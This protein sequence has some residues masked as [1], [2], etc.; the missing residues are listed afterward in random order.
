MRGPAGHAYGRGGHAQCWQAD[1]SDERMR[2]R[3]WGKV[4]DWCVG[5]A[6]TVARAETGA[7]WIGLGEDADRANFDLVS[8]V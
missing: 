6:G 2:R 7:G 5:G 3:R 8:H 4:I 1:L